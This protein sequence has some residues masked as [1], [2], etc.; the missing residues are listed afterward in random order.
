MLL[1]ITGGII[2][3]VIVFVLCVDDVEA[4][5]PIEM[6]WGDTLYVT[7]T[8]P[9]STVTGGWLISEVYTDSTKLRLKRIGAATW[10]TIRSTGNG[11][12]PGGNSGPLFVGP[13]PIGPFRVQMAVRTNYYTVA[14]WDTLTGEPLDSTLT[15]GWSPWASRVVFCLMPLGDRIPR[16]VR[17]EFEVRP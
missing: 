9:E 13:L 1:F 16:R 14:A 11:W 17:L 12:P 7:A 8:Y 2:A 4:R 15:G 3:A 5:P 6:Y 10:L